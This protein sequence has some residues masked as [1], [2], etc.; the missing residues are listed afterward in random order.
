[1]IYLQKEANESFKQEHG[2][3]C[4]PRRGLTSAVIIAWRKELIEAMIVEMERW[5]WIQKSYEV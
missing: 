3:I 1:M 4:G 2:L 5:D